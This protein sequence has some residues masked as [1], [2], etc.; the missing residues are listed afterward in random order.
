MAGIILLVW[1]AAFYMMSEGG[2]TTKS[3]LNFLY[4]PLYMYICLKHAPNFT[5]LINNFQ[6]SCSNESQPII[7]PCKYRVSF[8]EIGYTNILIDCYK[9]EN[10]SEAVDEIFKVIYWIGSRDMVFFKGWSNKS[11]WFKC[12]KKKRILF[13]ASHNILFALWSRCVPTKCRIEYQS[14]GPS[15]FGGRPL[16]F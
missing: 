8:T 14:Y 9:L 4:S 2:S 3:S 10:I 7:S 1:L 12:W 6:I 15:G 5:V 11:V 13:G 16:L